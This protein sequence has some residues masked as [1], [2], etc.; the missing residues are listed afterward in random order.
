MTKTLFAD[1]LTADTGKLTDVFLVAQCDRKNKKDGALYFSLKLQDRTG[2]V[3]AKLWEVP[4]DLTDLQ[5][6]QFVKVEAVTQSY[7][8]QL[9]LNIKRIRRVPREEVSLEDFIPASKHDRKDLFYGIAELIGFISKDKHPGLHDAVWALVTDNKAALM[10]CPAAKS[11]HQPYLGG[12]MEH[13]LSIGRAAVKI[14]ECYPQLDRDLLVAAA[15]VH[16]I[17]KLQELVWATNIGYSP[18]GALVGHVAEVFRRPGYGNQT[19]YDAP[20]S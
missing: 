14:C 3:V 6:G 13:I 9:Q 5:A 18:V 10:D 1:Q 7:K 20:D 15:V 8:D 17:G 12:L 19:A 11:L 16:D 2:D 4:E